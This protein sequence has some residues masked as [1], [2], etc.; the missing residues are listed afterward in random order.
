M[1][2]SK[3]TIKALGY[4]SYSFLSLSEQ[5]DDLHMILTPIKNGEIIKKDVRILTCDLDPEKH[6]PR[7]EI[8][9]IRD[10]EEM[11]SALYPFETWWQF[12]SRYE[13]KMDMKEL[14][15]ILFPFQDP[16]IAS[17]REEENS[18]TV[19][20][21]V[22]EACLE[23]ALGLSSQTVHLFK[24]LTH[25]F[26]NGLTQFFNALD[27]FSKSHSQFNR[28]TRR[29]NPENVIG[30]PG[31]TVPREKERSLNLDLFHDHF[32]EG[33]VLSRYFDAYEYRQ[34]Q[35]EM[36]KSVARAF[37]QQAFLVAEAGTGIGKSLAY[38][39][40]VLLW[41]AENPGQRVI[42]STQTKTLQHQL[43]TKELPF[44][45]EILPN[46]FHAVLLKGR[47]NYL[48]LKRWESIT[49]HSDKI[50]TKSERKQLLPL[51]IWAEETGDGDIELHPSYGSDI[52]Q[53]LWQKL[54]ADSLDCDRGRCPHESVCFVQRARKAA[55]QA[56]AVIVNHALLFSDLASSGSV[57]GPYSNLIMD[58]AHQI[59]KVASNHLGTRLHPKIIA[60]I[61]QFCVPARL[62]HKTLFSLFYAKA[63]ELKEETIFQLE[64]RLHVIQQRAE[65]LGQSSELF[66]RQIGNLNSNDS[67][68][69]NDKMRLIQSP[70]EDQLKE[71]KEEL[72]ERL[73][74]LAWAVSQCAKWI[75]DESVQSLNDLIFVCERLIDQID[76]VRKM[77]NHFQNANY[78]QYIVWQ[79]VQVQRDGKIGILHSVPLQIGQI[80]SEQLYPQLAR[81][82]FTSATLSIAGEFDYFIRQLGLDRIEQERLTTNLFGSPF[83]YEDQVLLGIPAFLPTPKEPGYADAASDLIQKVLEVHARGTLIL[84]TSNAMLQSTY[85]HVKESNVHIDRLLM[86]QGVD[87]NRDQLL[88]RFRKN[89]ESILF[90]TNSF[91]EGIDVPGP[92]LETLVITRIPFDVPTDPVVAARMEHIQKL[93]G[94]GF[95]NYTL[96]EAIIR[97]RQ[98]FGRLIRTSRDFG[99]MLILD[100]RLLKSQYGRLI[101]DSLP[102]R[103]TIFSTQNELFDAIN[104]WFRHKQ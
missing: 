43:F 12:I 7:T 14:R 67:H 58:E 38:L 99:L 75:G 41:L 28:K 21:T 8:V 25:H 1:P 6:F 36:A 102:A 18:E 23:E 86:A 16:S 104:T 96:P 55:K 92:A 82:V 53:S 77:L 26:S 13:P 52:Y 90:G 71:S 19:I 101:R 79:Q 4:E 73:I 48:C 80:L 61:V 31:I 9:L 35:K 74:S 24:R 81:C 91:W 100:M 54:N 66:F 49:H 47:A 39:L 89:Q 72:D 22:L 11:L 78:E 62:K 76:S 20:R 37:N 65:S 83:I 95:L 51:V 94:N 44:L 45:K 97:L 2:L 93:T 59:E 33:G 63:G 68:T 3:D 85:T 40:P 84:F 88:Q 98:G 34:D 57:L 103:A 70:F 50:L 27:D 32:A 56:G 46:P 64:K 5:S 15:Q 87:G 29:K 10:L 17:K 60:D 42:V 30:E 69:V